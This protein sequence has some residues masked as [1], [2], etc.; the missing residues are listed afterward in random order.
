MIQYVKRFAETKCMSFLIKD[1]DFLKRYYKIWNK[2]SNSIKKG[3]DSKLVHNEKY[4]TTKTNFYEGKI[5]TN[6]YDSLHLFIINMHLFEMGER[7]YPQLLS[8]ECK[9]IAKEKRKGKQIY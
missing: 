9:Y 6:F 1:N 7:Y 2:V 5:S 8:E 4:L 3:F